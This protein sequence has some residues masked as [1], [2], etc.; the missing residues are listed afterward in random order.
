MTLVFTFTDKWYI[1]LVKQP[2]GLSRIA[3]ILPPILLYGF[4]SALQTV[5]TEQITSLKQGMG[6]PHTEYI[7]LKEKRLLYFNS[8]TVC[9]D[10]THTQ[11]LIT[12]HKTH[13]TSAN[14][15]QLQILFHSW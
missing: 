13:A 6:V 4:L 2:R 1:Q 14:H 15:M 5:F 3:R 9:T 11:V 8:T 12:Q 10:I 7:N